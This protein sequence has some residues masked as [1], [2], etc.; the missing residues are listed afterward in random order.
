[1]EKIK[2]KLKSITLNQWHIAVI[3]IGIIFVSLGAFHSN[4]WFDE[5]Y[6][7]GL[8]RKSTRLNSS[9]RCTSRMPSSA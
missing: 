5:S 6:S 3:V 7:V 2:E 1:M 8:D 4:L 9:H